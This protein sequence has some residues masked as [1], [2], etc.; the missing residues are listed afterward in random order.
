MFY[1]RPDRENPRY[2]RRIG[3]YAV[4][5]ARLLGTSECET[6]ELARLL[7]TVAKIV[8]HQHKMRSCSISDLNAIIQDEI[9]A[10][11]YT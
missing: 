2:N 9:H 11:V 6:A 10:L 1:E 5:Q 4:H 7:I 3:E 8:F